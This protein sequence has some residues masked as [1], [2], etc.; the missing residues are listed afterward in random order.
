MFYKKYV[1]KNF[2]KFTRKHLCQS[3]RPATLLK[4]DTGTGV[5]LCIWRT[6]SSTFFYRAP[7][8]AVSDLWEHGP[9]KELIKVYKKTYKSTKERH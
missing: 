5:L 2:A 1:L 3:L 7:P 8:V 4:I 9:I 6:L